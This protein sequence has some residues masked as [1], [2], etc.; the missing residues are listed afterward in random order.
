MSGAELHR[1]WFEFSKPA[2]SIGLGYGAGVTAFTPDDAL[3]LL[4]EAVAPE[5]LPAVENV[6]A[7]IAFADLDQGHVVPNMHPFTERGVWFP[8]FRPY[9]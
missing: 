5:R 6:K 8:K 1:Y 7:D 2:V 3:V 9:S 4:S